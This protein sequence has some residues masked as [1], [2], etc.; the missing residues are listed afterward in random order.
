MTEATLYQTLQL[1]VR[2]VARV[3]TGEK[4]EKH[5]P[6]AVFELQLD[7]SWL[8]VSKLYP[9]STSAFAAMGRKYQKDVEKVIG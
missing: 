3:G 5:D 1:P 4:P 7:G 9:H 6:Y 8:Q 2:K